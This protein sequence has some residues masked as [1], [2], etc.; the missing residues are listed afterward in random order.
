[1]VNDKQKQVTIQQGDFDRAVITRFC[2]KFKIKTVI[3][4]D[5][6]FEIYLTSMS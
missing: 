5:I 6:D 3:E 2:N 1:M 4:S